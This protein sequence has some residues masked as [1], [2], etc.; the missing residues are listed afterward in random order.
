MVGEKEFVPQ[1]VVKVIKLKFPIPVP[2]QGGGN[3]NVSE[4]TLRRFKTK[5]LKNLPK[6]FVNKKGKGMEPAQLVPL[7]A[8][9][10]ELPESAIDEMDLEDLMVIA[11]GI[12]DFLSESLGTGKN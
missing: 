12:G 9:L 4:V 2:K 6:D 7:I 11:E 3:V 10:A 5:D 1:G 8:G